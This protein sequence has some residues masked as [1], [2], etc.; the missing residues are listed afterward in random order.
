MLVGQI[1]DEGFLSFLVSTA[2]IISFSRS[3]AAS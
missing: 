3:S 2:S 1:G